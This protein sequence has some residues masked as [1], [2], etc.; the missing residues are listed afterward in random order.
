MHGVWVK[1]WIV[2]LCVKDRLSVK[3]GWRRFGE[4]RPWTRPFLSYPQ[5]VLRFPSSHYVDDNSDPL[6]K[7]PCA[8]LQRRLFLGWAG[9]SVA[10]VVLDNG[11][12]RKGSCDRSFGSSSPSNCE[13]AHT[14][15][16]SKHSLSGHARKQNI[17]VSQDSLDFLTRRFSRLYTPNGGRSSGLRPQA[18]T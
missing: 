3:R 17:F 1:K 15:K 11:G 13:H 9:E 7:K 6:G 8:C 14:Y 5:S 16:A 4:R 2:D 12:R 18:S 10:G